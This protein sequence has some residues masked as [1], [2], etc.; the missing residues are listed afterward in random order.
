MFQKVEENNPLLTLISYVTANGVGDNQRRGHR[1]T[2]GKS[3]NQWFELNDKSVIETMLINTDSEHWG[4]CSEFIRYFIEHQFPNLLQHL[5]DEAIQ[6][7]MLSVHRG[8]STFRYQSNFTTWLATIA[9][10][11]AI[12]ALRRHTEITRWE[13]YPDDPP[14]SNKDKAES[15]LTNRPRT[16]E[17]IVLTRE[18]I[19]E[20]LA[21]IEAYL[22]MRAN[23]ERNRQI[24]QM[25]LLE[26]K[27]YEETAQILGV[28]APVVGYVARTARSYLRQEPPHVSESST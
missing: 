18:R 15:S 20:T 2:E 22:Q 3:R 21:A 4:R 25:V 5:K 16:P 27:S 23:A 13:E 24:L 10:N 12:D 6:D 28:P 14:E 1:M 26:G 9:R 11:R 8:L 7:T 19:L 17:E